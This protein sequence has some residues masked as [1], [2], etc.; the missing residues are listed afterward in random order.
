MKEVGHSEHVDQDG[1]LSQVPDD[2]SAGRPEQCR[3][4]QVCRQEPHGR[5]LDGFFRFHT[6]TCSQLKVAMGGVGSDRVLVFLRGS[7]L[8]KIAE[9]RARDALGSLLSL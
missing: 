3:T 6:G 8:V 2:G 7:P 4:G 9:I 1:G 5:C